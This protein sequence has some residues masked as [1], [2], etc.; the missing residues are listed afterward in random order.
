MILAWDVGP[1]NLLVDKCTLD[2]VVVIDWENTR[3][4]PEEC[5]RLWGA[6]NDDYYALYSNKDALGKFI[7][8]LEVE[9][10]F[11]TA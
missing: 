10:P 11:S 6:T 4:Y 9:M 3:Y 2:V 8:A 1:G 5:C 7:K